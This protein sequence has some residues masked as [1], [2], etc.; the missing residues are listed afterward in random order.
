[1]FK[2][3]YDTTTPRT[4]RLW[5]LREKFFFLQNQFKDS[6]KPVMVSQPALTVSNE[7]NDNYLIFEK[8][9]DILRQIHLYNNTLLYFFNNIVF[10]DQMGK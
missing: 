6:K 4:L 1:M 2:I 8:K 5:S 10:Y 7:I 9:M 3:R